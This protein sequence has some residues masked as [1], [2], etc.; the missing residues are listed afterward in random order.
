MISG[1]TVTGRFTYI[2]IAWKIIIHKR[3]LLQFEFI[4][5]C[6]QEQ[7]AY[8]TVNRRLSILVTCLCTLLVISATKYWP[9]M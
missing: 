2:Q 9:S 5:K 1:A 6:F 4:R 3:A 7:V 8:F